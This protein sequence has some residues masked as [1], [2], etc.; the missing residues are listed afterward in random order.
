MIWK[1]K[2]CKVVNVVEDDNFEDHVRK[3]VRELL[4]WNPKNKKQKNKNLNVEEFNRLNLS[5]NESD[6]KEEGEEWPQYRVLANIVSRDLAKMFRRSISKYLTDPLI[7]M[8]DLWDLVG[9]ILQKMTLNDEVSGHATSDYEHFHKTWNSMENH[10]HNK[11]IME[12]INNESHQRKY[13]KTET[14][15]TAQLG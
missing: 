13:K 3:T 5:N 8:E 9:G 6:F 2:T 7:N 11:N 12:V 1:S 4:P 10:T 14:Q 15:H